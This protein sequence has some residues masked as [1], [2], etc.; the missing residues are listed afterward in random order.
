MPLPHRRLP[1]ARA[2]D[3]EE[4]LAACYFGRE[5]HL[6]V[7]SAI[8]DTNTTVG[9]ELGRVCLVGENDVVAGLLEPCDDGAQR[10]GSVETHRYPAL[11]REVAD[12][13]EDAAGGTISL[14]EIV[15]PPVFAALVAVVGHPLH[16]T[17]DLVA[18]VLV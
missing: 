13:H 16:R 2:E 1:R 17:E 4:G 12:N 14:G 15:H 10:R 8:M 18:V 7:N 6:A 3:L 11:D 9:A 5:V